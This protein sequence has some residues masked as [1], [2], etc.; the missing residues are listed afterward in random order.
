M[1][2]N[3]NNPRPKFTYQGETHSLKEW[4]EIA[5]VSYQLMRNRLKQMSLAEAIAKG[6]EKAGAI[7]TPNWRRF[8][9]RRKAMDAKRAK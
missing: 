6:S 8:L 4:A 5:G 3:P 1:P 9:K 2:R 7:D